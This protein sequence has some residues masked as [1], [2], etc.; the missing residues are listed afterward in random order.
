MTIPSDLV[1]LSSEIDK[2]STKAAILAR[3]WRLLPSKKGGFFLLRCQP[4]CCKIVYITRAVL[5]EK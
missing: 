5:H 3:E 2:I 1:S 4:R